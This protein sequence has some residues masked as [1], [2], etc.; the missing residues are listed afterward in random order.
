MQS[1]ENTRLITLAEAARCPWLPR[2]N[3]GRTIHKHTL[4]RW[5]TNGLRGQRLKTALVGGIRCTTESWLFE[6]IFND[7]GD[8]APTPLPRSKRKQRAIRAEREVRNRLRLPQRERG[9]SS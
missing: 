4:H 2:R 5:A 9:E 8:T 7:Q 1:I 6:F 3:N